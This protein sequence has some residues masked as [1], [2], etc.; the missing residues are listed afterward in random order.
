[1]NLI[2]AYAGRFSFQ[3]ISG[4]FGVEGTLASAFIGTVVAVVL[5]VVVLVIMLKVD[6]ESYLEKYLASGEESAKAESSS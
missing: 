6:W 4:F 3:A 5:L 1:M 2:V